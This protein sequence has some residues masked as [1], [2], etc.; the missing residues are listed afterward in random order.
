MTDI[1]ATKEVLEALTVIGIEAKK[2]AK[3]GIS[4]ADLPEALELFKHIDLFVAAIKD[5]KLIPSEMKDLDQAEA[6]EL[7]TKVYLDVKA[8][9]EA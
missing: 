3:D 2:I 6:I 7:G 8:I 4:M 5:A 1:K 9:I